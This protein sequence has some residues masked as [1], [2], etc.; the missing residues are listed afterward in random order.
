MLQRT[1]LERSAILAAPLTVR[2][3]SDWKKLAPPGCN[4]IVIGVVLSEMFVTPIQMEKN[5]WLNV[6]I[7]ITA[8]LMSSYSMCQNPRLFDHILFRNLPTSQ[9]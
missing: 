2:V 6:S 7:L 8:L 4:D 1:T 3:V 5:A 9:F